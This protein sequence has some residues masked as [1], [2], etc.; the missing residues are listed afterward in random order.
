MAPP[1][2]APEMV[3]SKASA[4]AG[5][6][7]SHLQ[8]TRRVARSVGL[9]A[10][11]VMDEGLRYFDLGDMR[12]ASAAFQR[13]TGL[14]P[15][16]PS[17]T[18]LGFAYFYLGDYLRATNIFEKATK[19]D[20]LDFH[21]FSGLG[22]ALNKLG[23]TQ[24]AIKAFRRALQLNP[25][26]AGVHFFL[27]Y[28]YSELKQWLEAE[29][30]Y[31][32]AIQL[33]KD[34]LD[35]YQY[36]ADMYL[37][38]GRRSGDQDRFQQAV[39]LYY[40]LME[41]N[42]EISAAYN[43]IGVIYDEIGRKQEALAAFEKAVKQASQDVT[44]LFNL[45][46]AYLSAGRFREARP[47]WQRLV[48]ILEKDPEPKR[49]FLAQAYN[50]LGVSITGEYSL[51]EIEHGTTDPELLTE[52]EYIFKKAIEIDSGYV[53]PYTGLGAV[54]YRQGREDEAKQTFLKA[55][56]L[57]PNSEA[58]KDNLRL[59]PLDPIVRATWEQIEASKHGVPVDVEGLAD[60]VVQIQ[61]SVIAEHEREPRLEVFTPEDLVVVLLPV[62]IEMDPDTRF[63]FAAK[64]FERDMLSSGKAAR[65]ANT[66]R[67]TFLLDLHKVGV[68]AID[69]D[70]EQMESQVRYVNSR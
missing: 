45:G 26:D 16:G 24:K 56:E 44:L 29:R 54:Y 6:Q 38:L 66:D 30:E 31:R 18:L 11:A 49:V 5:Q 46:S 63:S 57:D 47:V 53:D 61:Q 69:L 55:L 51:Q 28:L 14:L 39:D 67:V 37:E 19:L 70:E 4:F 13:L 9:D 62:V 36:L 12:S 21:T 15:T 68:A 23:K 25:H 2:T 58:A 59:I 50:N 52:A 17:Y 64:L 34:F 1:R 42:P 3:L 40:E 65:L 35:A 60:K 33:R 41:N 27:G 10:K 7:N 8:N 43:N 32:E 22:L 48:D 20:P